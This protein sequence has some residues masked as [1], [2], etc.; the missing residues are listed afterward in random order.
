MFNFTSDKT[1]ESVEDSLKRLGVKYLDIVQLHDVEFCASNQQLLSHTIPALLKLK[2]AGKIK[3]IGVT[4]YPLDILKDLVNQVETGTISTVL[5]YCRATLF[6]RELLE[7]LPFF[8]EKGVGVI[9]ASPVA[10]GLLSNRGPPTWHPA[11]QKLKEACQQAAL[12][13][14]N[15]G[16]NITKLALLWTLRQEG[17]PTTLVSTSSMENL[18]MNLDAL[19]ATLSEREEQILAEIDKTYFKPLKGAERNWLRFEVVRYWTNMKDQGA[20]QPIND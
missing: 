17:L 19:S 6:D 2:K 13:C 5:S 11:N 10:M 20:S 14:Q 18:R 16:A 3:H 15:E 4:G 1:L 12:H 7:D 9:N 8:N